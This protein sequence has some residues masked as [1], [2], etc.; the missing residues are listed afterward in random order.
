MT[1]A[2]KEGILQ[3]CRIICSNPDSQT[4]LFVCPTG[5]DFVSK[6]AS[7]NAKKR[8]NK[9]KDDGNDDGE[10][11]APA[12]D[13]AGDS[14]AAP[15]AAPSGAAAAAAATGIS[16]ITLQQQQQQ[17]V[18]S[19][20]PAKRARALQKKLRQVC[21]GGKGIV[22]GDGLRDAIRMRWMDSHCSI[23]VMQQAALDG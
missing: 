12:A 2:H 3:V 18:A 22:R 9:K 15:R 4:L 13:T 7:K 11:G 8:A 21:A 17:E 1:G 6:T 5:C 19:D 20:D 16:S 23:S 10:E 14:A